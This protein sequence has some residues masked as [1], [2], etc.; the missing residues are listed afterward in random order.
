MKKQD[1]N[2]TITVDATPQAA[3]QAINDVTKW[4]TEDLEGSTQRRNDV[5][6]VHF[7]ETY[8]THRIVEG[9]PGKK[10]VWR[11]T[12]CHKHFLKNKKEWKDTQISFEISPKG[13]STQIHFTHTGLVPEVECYGVCSN[14]WDHYIKESLFKL[15]TEG[16]G[17]PEVRHVNNA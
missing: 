5:F 12:D 8:I 17:T 10:I 4:W 6:T 15:L 14:A 9:T 7:G 11:V 1:Y 3:F 16:K 13:G 2:T